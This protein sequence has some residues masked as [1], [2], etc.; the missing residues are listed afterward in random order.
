CETAVRIDPELRE[1]HYRLGRLYQQ[2]GRGEDA[3]REMVLF[4]KLDEEAHRQAQYLLGAKMG[5][6]AQ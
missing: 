1:A 3:H 4:R 5:M 2:L 6:P